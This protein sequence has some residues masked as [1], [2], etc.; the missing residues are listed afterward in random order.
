VLTSAG[1]SDVFIA[2]FSGGDGHHLWS[3]AVGG[4]ADDLSVAIG[5]TRQGT[6]AVLGVYAGTVNFGAGPSH[7]SPGV[8][9]MFLAAFDGACQA[10]WSLGFGDSYDGPKAVGADSGGN[11]VVTGSFNHSIDFG[12]GVLI[13]NPANSSIFLAKLSGANGGQLWAHAFLG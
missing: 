6:F 13:A 8:N 2:K 11:F 12:N 4:M 10:A 7:T 3:K 1:G 9:Q 5:T